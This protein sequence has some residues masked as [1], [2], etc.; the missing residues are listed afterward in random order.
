MSMKTN[1]LPVVRFKKDEFGIIGK[2][3]EIQLEAVTLLELNNVVE[4]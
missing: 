4:L 2:D 1:R 3:S